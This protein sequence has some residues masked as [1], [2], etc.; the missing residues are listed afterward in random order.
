MHTFLLSVAFHTYAPHLTIASISSGVKASGV[1]AV[2][3]VKA[4]YTCYH[5]YCLACPQESVGH[6]VA[7]IIH[8]NML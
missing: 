2:F 5:L 6:A 8:T 3:R 1:L 7:S 4:A